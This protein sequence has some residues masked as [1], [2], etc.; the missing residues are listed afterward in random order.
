MV[1]V[2]YIASPFVANIHLRLPRYARNSRQLLTRYWQTLP[3]DAKL[4]ITTMNWIG[5]PRVSLVNVSDL[6]HV[7]QR[8]GMVNYIRDTKEL[9]LKRPWWMG[10]AVKQFGVHGGTKIKDG[11][12][13]WEAIAKNV[14]KRSN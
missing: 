14:A 8:F 5:K 7:K 11:S 10:K 3:K 6:K 12:G 13:I 9:N 1:F 4:D 2:T